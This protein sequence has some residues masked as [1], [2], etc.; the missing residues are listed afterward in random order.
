MF[1]QNNLEISIVEEM[2]PR[3]STPA[4]TEVVD[5]PAPSVIKPV[6]VSNV[7]V[8]KVPELDQSIVE[9]VIAEGVV[10]EDD[11][12]SDLE[13]NNSTQLWEE[14]YL[15]IDFA[16]EFVTFSELVDAWC[17]DATDIDYV[18][19]KSPDLTLVT[20]G[21]P[22]RLVLLDRKGEPVK[23]RKRFYFRSD[24]D[25]ETFVSLYEKLNLVDYC[26]Q[27]A[28]YDCRL[29]KLCCM[30]K[31]SWFSD[32]NNTWNLAGML[33]RKQHV[34][35]R[36]MRKTYLCSLK[37]M[38]DRFDETAALKVFN[39]WETSKYHP[40]LS[41]SQ[42]K[43]I[44]GGTDPEGYKQWKAEYEPKELKE[45][46]G[47]DEDKTK[48]DDLTVPYYPKFNIYYEK[49]ELPPIFD[50]KNAETYLD[51]I[52]LKK[53]VITMERLYKIEMLSE[54]SIT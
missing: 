37:T 6:E 47:K 43:S 11:Q 42:I 9:P 50:C 27:N 15:K 22:T 34:D 51:V 29:Y 49:G 5:T 18:R 7:E 1:E 3:V 25:K 16:N 13:L 44:A 26:L 30:M 8:S 46:K 38:T 19:L 41:E 40:K 45:K 39:D 20:K 32:N 52:S 10:Y 48:Q 14:C 54:I 53:E 28:L 21:Y 31:R 4:N 2:S 35:L 36:L 23:G 33:Y 24:Q 17:S 12:S